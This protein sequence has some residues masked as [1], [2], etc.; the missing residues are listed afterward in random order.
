MKQ[1]LGLVLTVLCGCLSAV[2]AQ[3]VREAPIEPS[4]A[5]KAEFFERQVRPVLAEHCFACHGAGKQQSGL[6]LDSR[7]AVIKGGENGLTYRQ[8]H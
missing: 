6:R 1:T 5:M 8:P 7:S 4:P 2:D 3:D